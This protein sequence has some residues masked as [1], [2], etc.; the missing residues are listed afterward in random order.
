M[1]KDKNGVKEVTNPEDHS[2]HPALQLYCVEKKCSALKSLLDNFSPCEQLT[3]TQQKKYRYNHNFLNAVTWINHS[4]SRKWEDE[5]QLHQVQQGR[6]RLTG[7]FYLALLHLVIRTKKFTLFCSSS[8]VHPWKTLLILQ[9]LALCLT[10]KSNT[11]LWGEKRCFFML[12]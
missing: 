8:K 6:H 9:A 11:A 4:K 3:P 5:I 2:S 12:Y 7:H 1:K 10:S